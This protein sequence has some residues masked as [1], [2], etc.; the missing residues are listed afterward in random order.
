MWCRCGDLS[1]NSTGFNCDYEIPGDNTGLLWYQISDDLWGKQFVS[2]SVV[3]GYIMFGLACL[4]LIAQLAVCIAFFICQAPI[5]A[6]RLCRSQRK[7][8]K[9]KKN[10]RSHSSVQVKQS[11]SITLLTPLLWL[12]DM[13]IDLAMLAVKR[14]SG[15]KEVFAQ[16][17]VPRS[18]PCRKR[19]LRLSS[20]SIAPRFA[21]L[22]APFPARSLTARC[23]ALLPS[24][25]SVPSSVAFLCSIFPSALPPFICTLPAL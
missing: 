19:L 8:P 15:L 4:H 7:L 5:E 23:S 6:Y 9:T 20:I 16:L 24:C 17:E 22:S 14:S 13:L 1:S 12:S 18:T 10:N 3:L 11:K 25:A 21:L 2:N